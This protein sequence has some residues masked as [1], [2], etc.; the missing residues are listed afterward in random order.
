LEIHLY[1]VPDALKNSVAYTPLHD[2]AVACT[3]PQ[4]MIGQS[5]NID[6]SLA[7]SKV[8]SPGMP[9]STKQESRVDSDTFAK[10]TQVT[11][12]AYS[13][14]LSEYSIL[15]DKR[16]WE[17]STVSFVALVA[18][19]YGAAFDISPTIPP[20]QS[21]EPTIVGFH[22][23]ILPKQ[24][25]K[26][27]FFLEVGATFR[28][29]EGKELFTAYFLASTLTVNVSDTPLPIFTF[30]QVT[31]GGILAALIGSALNVPWILERVQKSRKKR[32]KN[33]PPASPPL[34]HS[35]PPSSRRPRRRRRR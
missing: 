14:I 26:Q 3:L 23:N 34:R 7:S 8:L 11:D 25:G 2:L 21:A 13:N 15:N 35:S 33:S 18:N 30:G 20:S 27:A 31:L 28:N 22:W 19:L 5:V 17:D 24:A 29:Q 9:S 6:M 1:V 32:K 10:Y 12:W 16:G 4:L